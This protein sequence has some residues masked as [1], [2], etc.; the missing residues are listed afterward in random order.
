MRKEQIQ[1]LIDW[2][3]HLEHSIQKLG[4]YQDA[5]EFMGPVT[6]TH[7]AKY[8]LARTTLTEIQYQKSLLT[9]AAQEAQSPYPEEF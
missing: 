7:C 4:N 3:T 2:L 6:L 5:S 1:E 9:V 8:H